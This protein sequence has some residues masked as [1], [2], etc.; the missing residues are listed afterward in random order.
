MISKAPT[1]IEPPEPTVVVP[2]TVR[3]RA[4]ALFPI[5]RLPLTVRL[6]TVT[7]WSKVI[8]APATIVTS[9]LAPGTTPPDHDVPSLQFPPVAVDDMFVAKPVAVS[10]IVSNKTS[11]TVFV[12]FFK[13]IFCIFSQ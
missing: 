6:A 13:F 8:V 10:P 9:S 4:V 3:L 1:V 5:T 11:N 7:S 12:I 2:L